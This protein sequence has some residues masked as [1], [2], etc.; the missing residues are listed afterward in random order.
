MGNIKIRFVKSYVDV[1]NKNYHLLGIL[2]VVKNFKKIPDL[3]KALAIKRIK[4]IIAELTD[5]E[6]KDLV[7]YALAYPPRTRAF[8]GALLESIKTKRKEDLITLKESL[9]PLSSYTI[10]VTQDVLPN[11]KNWFIQ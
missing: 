10:G 2:D 3:N 4:V 7:K 1:N 9:N 5:R 8:L 11:A 6:Q